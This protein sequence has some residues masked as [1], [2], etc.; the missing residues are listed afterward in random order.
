MPS[1]HASI[2][3]EQHNGVPGPRAALIVEAAVDALESATRAIAGELDLDRVLQMIVDGVRDLVQARYAALGIVDDRGR[4]ERFITSGMTAGERLAIGPTPRGHGLLGL[5]IKEARAYRVTDIA[6]HP[7]TSGFP[8]NHPPMT[9]F[10]GVPVETGGEPIGNFYLTDKIGAVEFSEQDQRLVEMFALHAEVAIQNARLH[11][12][13]QRLAV[14][15]ERLRIARDLH[16]GIIQGLYAVA[17]SLEDVPDIMAVDSAE[18]VARIDR[19][20]D[21]LN[22]SIG[23]IRGFIMDLGSDAHAVALGARM[24]ALTDELLLT[25]GGRLALDHD[26]TEADAVGEGLSFEAASQLLLIAREA[27]SNAIRHGRAARVHLSVRV[28]EG[29]AV[30]GV[31]DDGVGFDPAVP[32]PN[33]HLGL[34]NLRDRA[35]AVGGDLEIDSHPGAGTRIIVRLPMVNTER[36]TP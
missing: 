10:L 35:A 16:D 19:A 28:E 29:S 31:E 20:I 34:A 22:T 26:L 33:G 4:I 7:A 12:R 5:I 13:V 25:S 18:A 6:R 3:P 2:A 24:A 8:P 9:S 11:S 36:L 17:L 23:E 1:D 32:P 14:L 27:L 21:R 15:D 30:L